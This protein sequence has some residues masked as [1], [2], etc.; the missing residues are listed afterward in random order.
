MSAR[1]S[2]DDRPTKN[3]SVY[4]A[5]AGHYRRG[6]R[7]DDEAVSISPYTTQSI[8]KGD[9][10]I[11]IR[12]DAPDYNDLFIHKGTTILPD[13]LLAKKYTTGLEIP[14]R[15]REEFPPENQLPASDLLKAIHYYASAKVSG[16]TDGS[17]SKSA[18]GMIR[19]MDETALL[20]MGKLVEEWVDELV[21]GECPRVWAHPEPKEKSSAMN[22]KGLGGD[23]GENNDDN[24]LSSDWSLA[25]GDMEVEG[26]SDGSASLDAN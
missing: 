7:F 5:A 25:E 21:D 22:W 4:T 23:Y 17:G 18:D 16:S 9:P 13:E 19:S 26:D 11:T 20:C 10:L 1:Q 3:A 24:V 6:V 15:P 2:H 8:Q 14:L 12:R